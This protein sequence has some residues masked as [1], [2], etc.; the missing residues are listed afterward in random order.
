MGDRAGEGEVERGQ[1]GNLGVIFPLFF[2]FLE[3]FF[4]IC[5]TAKSVASSVF[6]GTIRVFL[7]PQ[8]REL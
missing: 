4:G 5:F 3:T 1:G 8:W 7:R 6:F 2:C